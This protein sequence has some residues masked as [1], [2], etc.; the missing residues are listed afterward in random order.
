MFRKTLF[1]LT[2]EELEKIVY[3]MAAEGKEPIG[4]DGRH[5]QAER[6]LVRAA[7]V[8]RLFLPEFRAGDQPPLDYL[9]ERNITDLR[10]FLGRRP[11]IFFAK[12][13]L[14]LEEALE[15][16]GPI[17]SLGQMRFIEALSHLR[18][19]QSHIIPRIFPMLFERD[20]GVDGFRP[21]VDALA[22]AVLQGVEQGQASSS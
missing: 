11:N 19:S 5:G 13:L 10:V 16:P 4:L 17:L 6:L 15:L 18:P 9:R 7:P 12:D 8:L 20:G 1:T 22:A 3:P 14:P 2:Q 21:A